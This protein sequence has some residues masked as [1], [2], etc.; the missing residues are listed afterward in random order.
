M[1]AHLCS[2]N[3][4]SLIFNILLGV[5]MLLFFM[6]GY[7]MGRYDAITMLNPYVDTFHSWWK[8]QWTH[9]REVRLLQQ[10]SA[11]L[12]VPLELAAPRDLHTLRE[13]GGSAFRT[14]MA[15]FRGMAIV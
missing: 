14:A 2:T 10:W 11:G 8:L 15:V 12:G 4:E 9:R 7:V 3:I 5:C 13:V 1:V 6:S